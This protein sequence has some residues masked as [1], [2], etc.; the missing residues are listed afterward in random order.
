MKAVQYVLIT[1]ARDEAAQ[2][3]HTLQAMV[4]QTVSPLKWVIVSD[5][6][7]DGTDD[8]VAEYAAKHPWIKLLRMP[9]RKERHFGGKVYA[10][11]AGYD[12]VKD[13]DY[14]VIGNLDADSS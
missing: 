13:L 1:P 8:I 12:L 11:R 14:E 3:R 5:G 7:T 4:A 9:E 10:F 2:I 6:S